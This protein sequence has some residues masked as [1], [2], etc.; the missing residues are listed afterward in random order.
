VANGPR[1]GVVIGDMMVPESSPNEAT[2][3]CIAPLRI[4]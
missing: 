3:W 1:H 2:P 4:S